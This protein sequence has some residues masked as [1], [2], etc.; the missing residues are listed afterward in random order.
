[1]TADGPESGAS[2]EDDA[3]PITKAFLERLFGVL[4]DDFATLKQEIAADVKDLNSEMA[5]VGQRQNEKQSIRTMKE[6]TSLLDILVVA[7]GEGSSSTL[8][9]AQA[10]PV[11]GR[12]RRNKQRKGKMHKPSEDESR[13]E[14]AALLHRLRSQESEELL[15]EW[16][17]QL[18]PSSFGMMDIL[19][20][21]AVR[22][23]DKLLEEISVL[24]HEIKSMN[25]PEV[26]YKN[27][28]IL[29]DV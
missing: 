16:G 15:K 17:Q 21:D 10:M 7:Q 1:M 2:Q 28:T 5:E 29:N 18:V 26:A 20:R 25:Q 8:N 23:K 12:N 3:S 6:A 27:Y 22:K 14:S 13:Q 4:R 11:E 9:H 19:I 24:E